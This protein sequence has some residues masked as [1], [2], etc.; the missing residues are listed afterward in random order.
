MQFRQLK[1]GCSAEFKRFDIMSFT[2]LIRLNLYT[3]YRQ[4]GYRWCL[5]TLAQLSQD[6]QVRTISDQ[7]L[8][9]ERVRRSNTD[10]YPGPN[11]ASVG[12]QHDLG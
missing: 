10:T 5:Y 6:V 9:F 2:Y 11:V 4:F 1:L 12:F 8:Q 3:V 7:K